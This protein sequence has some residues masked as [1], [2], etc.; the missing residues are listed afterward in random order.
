MLYDRKNKV[1][2]RIKLCYIN[3][4]PIYTTVSKAKEEVGKTVYTA[5]GCIQFGKC[6]KGLVTKRHHEGFG[7]MIEL[8]RA[9]NGSMAYDD[10][11][12]KAHRTVP[13]GV[14]F[15]VGIKNKPMTS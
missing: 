4:G 15:T 6:G 2:A 1:L 13:A 3:E 5:P 7:R 12:G 14:N 11:F 10:T 8:S 9:L